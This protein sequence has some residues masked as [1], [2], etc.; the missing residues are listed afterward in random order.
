M[1]FSDLRKMR[2]VSGDMS[3]DE[4]LRSYM[5]GVYALMGLGLLITALAAYVISTMSIASQ[6]TP[7]AQLLSIGGGQAIYLTHFG[8]ALFFTPL[9]YV[10]MFAPLVVVFILGFRINTLSTQSARALFIL[11]AA[12]VGASLSSIFLVYSY[13]TIAE[14]FLLS[15]ASFGSLSLYGY[16]TKRDLQPLGAFLFMAVIGLILASLVNLFVHSAS[17]SYGLSILS[18]LIFAGLTA[19]DTQVIKEFYYAGDANDTRDRKIIMGALNL[20]IDFINIFISLLQIL[21]AD[22]G[23]D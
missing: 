8:Q 18:V 12:L 7:G 19:Y 14:S 6:A 5:V 1:N 3:L 9:R 16:V 15:A 23:R 11:Y 21:G 4:G 10:L 2:V 22:R 17:F 20:Y 13:N